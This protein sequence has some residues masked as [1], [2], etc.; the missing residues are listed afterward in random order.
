MGGDRL[1]YH[2]VLISP[3]LLKSRALFFVSC[4]G[5]GFRFILPY[6]SHSFSPPNKQLHLSGIMVLLGVK[7]LINK[8]KNVIYMKFC[9]SLSSSSSKSSSFLWQ[10]V[11]V[12]S[13][14][15][16]RSFLNIPGLIPGRYP[17]ICSISRASIPYGTYPAPG[18]TVADVL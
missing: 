4:L 12:G 18:R 16:G 5:L 17:F 15:I 11:V 3:Y 1:A 7:W 10:N 14:C 13:Q 8:K 9:S 6:F 2:S